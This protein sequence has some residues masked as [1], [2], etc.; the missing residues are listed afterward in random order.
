MKPFT[1]WNGIEIEHRPFFHNACSVWRVARY[2]N[3]E[4]C[5]SYE[6]VGFETYA[7][8]LKECNK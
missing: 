8:C 7:D 5:T 6:N 1:N 4:F 3:G 2:E